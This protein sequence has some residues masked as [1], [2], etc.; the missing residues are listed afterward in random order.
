MDHNVPGAAEESTI[1]VGAL[2]TQF[3]NSSTSQAPAWLID[4]SSNACFV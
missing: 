3:A 2:V 4:E 1:P